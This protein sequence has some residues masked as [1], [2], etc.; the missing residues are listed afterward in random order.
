MTTPGGN[1]VLMKVVSDAAIG[2]MVAF[3]DELLMRTPGGASLGLNAPRMSSSI[4]SER[5][6]MT[7]A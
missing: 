2:V 5:W 4:K 6:E 1:A 3:A 7:G